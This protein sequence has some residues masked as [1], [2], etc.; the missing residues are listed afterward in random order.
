MT[1]RS[2]RA[3]L[4]PEIRQQA[5]QLIARM[6]LDEKVG[7]MTQYDWGFNPI[8]PETGVSVRDL[9]RDEIRQGRVGSIFNLSGAEEAN[10][11]QRLIAEH[12]EHRIPLLIGRDVI[13]GYK[14]VFPIP[15]AQASAWNPA[16]AYRTAEAASRE[17]MADGVAWVFA[18]MIDVSRDPRWGRIAESIG[19]DPLLTSQYSRAWVEG[20]QVADAPGQATAS[21]P[22]HYA[23]YGLAEAGRDYNTV[24][25]SDREL[26]DVILPPFRE[27]VEAGALSIMA[28]FNEINGIPACANEYLLKTI[29]RDEWGFEGIVASDYNALQELIVHGVAGS[30]EEACELA[31]L[32]GCDMDMHSGFYMRHLPKLVREGRVPASVV[33]TS[34]LRILAVKIKLGL[35][36]Q[37][38]VEV[39]SVEAAEAARVQF[40]ALAREAAQQSIVLLRNEAQV[41][42][43]QKSG[44][45]IAVIGPFAHNRKDPLGCWA[46]DGK[47]EDVVSLLD[48][49]RHAVGS[50]A[51]VHYAEGCSVS[52]DTMAASGLTEA[53]I[54]QVL[55]AARQSDVVVLALGESLEMSGES[56]SRTSLDLPGAQRQLVEA[57][58]ALG[59]PIVAVLMSGRPLALPWL[60]QYASAIMQAWHLGVQSGNAIAD[61]LFGDYNPS[62]R[63]PV[64][65][66]RSV[67]Q[68]PIYYY[69]KKTGRPP[70]GVYSSY[71]IDSTTEPLYP[72]GY[73]LSYTAFQ[74][75]A[76]T[77][78]DASIGVAGKSSVSVT[79]TNTGDTAGTEI[80]QCYIRDEVASVTQ[81]L[82]KLIGFCRLQLAPGESGYAAFEIGERQ[83]AI[84]DKDMKRTVE[85]GRFTIWV[86][87][88]AS[89]GDAVSI[90]VE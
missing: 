5:E 13:H 19:E 8:N 80:V 73:G 34:V 55:E 20:S 41:L 69:R 35:L 40:T 53:N 63:L 38:F 12:T 58:A 90:V 47:P 48:G 9:L 30:E 81:P 59:K 25:L 2:T 26:R 32:A 24:D 75:S 36:E 64:T 43:L 78:S 68:V 89:S 1:E 87:P 37:P 46:F 67:G 33:D 18:P 54:E 77:V 14:T 16:L 6:S 72:F 74:Y 49:I 84:L 15:L 82:K 51:A 83:L 52:V 57:V 44:S 27:A 17:S 10:E 56:R 3:W 31:V 76:I 62:G 85:P 29:L 65:V 61:V 4:T 28:S 79:V 50:S 7:Q 42:P 39:P 22:K 71:Y 45:S 70:G 60:E 21:C 86:G 23:G 66:P 88:N 11:L